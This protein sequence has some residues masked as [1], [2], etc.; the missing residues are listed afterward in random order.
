[1]GF[2]QLAV[3]G[4]VAA[5]FLVQFLIT[6][7][8]PGV[9]DTVNSI[10]AYQSGKPRKFFSMNSFFRQVAI[11]KNIYIVSL[12]FFLLNTKLLSL[13]CIR[14]FVLFRQKYIKVKVQFEKNHAVLRFGKLL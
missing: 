11:N 2:Y 3:V 6:S 10:K 12:I 14:I 9:Q 8:K 1:M 7:S 13:S 4:T 5:I